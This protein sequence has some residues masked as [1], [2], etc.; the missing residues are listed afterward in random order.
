M[1]QIAVL[2]HKQRDNDRARRSVNRSGAKRLV[3]RGIACWISATIIRIV[4][5]DELRARYLAAQTLSTPW[6]P[7]ELP[8][9][10]FQDPLIRRN[11]DAAIVR[12]AGNSKTN[13]LGIEDSEIDAPITHQDR[14]RM[15]ADFAAAI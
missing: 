5:P 1:A 13:R 2:D 3:A 14:E 11:P 15:F 8:G 6:E 12:D 4:P 9:L 10:T 7:I